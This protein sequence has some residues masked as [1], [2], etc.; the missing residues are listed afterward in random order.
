[1]GEV[2]PAAFPGSGIETT[3]LSQR[4]ERRLQM[5]L[6]YDLVE[7]VAGAGF[8]KTTILEYLA[9]KGDTAIARLR[10]SSEPVLD[11]LRAICDAAAEMAP[12]AKLTVNDA[13]SNA[14]FHDDSIGALA[15][16]WNTHLSGAG[17]RI[18]LDDLHLVE[19]HIGAW[20]LIEKLIEHSRGRVSW[21]LAS[22]S[23][24]QLPTT[25]WI[26][27]G[28]MGMPLTAD[29]L[30]FT[31]D[32]LAELAKQYTVELAAPERRRIIERT[33]GWPLVTAHIVRIWDKRHD[34]AT[35]IEQARSRGI[36]AMAVPLWA[37]LSETEQRMLLVASLLDSAWPA[38]L[39]DIGFQN[40]DAIL[41]TLPARGVPISR[42]KAGA[43]R[44]HDLLREHL[45]DHEREALNRE[46][47]IAIEHLVAVDDPVDALVIA[48]RL[49]AADKIPA[50]MAS[51]PALF[52]DPEDTALVDRA[53]SIVPSRVKNSD[54]AV[55]AVAASRAYRNGSLDR[56]VAL[57]ER[58]I[59][60]GK[61]NLRA[62]V[63]RRLA[64]LQVNRANWTD[65]CRLCDI[66][67]GSVEVGNFAEIAEIAGT[68]GVALANSGAHQDAQFAI[69]AALKN[70]AQ[71]DDAKLRARTFQRAGLVAFVADR[72]A[73]AQEAA[74]EAAWIA[75]SEGAQDIIMRVQMLLYAIAL[76]KGEPN[77]IAAF[78]AE[79]TV[80]A[81]ARAADR[82]HM[83]T[84]LIA[85]LAL[86]AQEGDRDR[87]AHLRERLRMLGTT[88]SVHA[89]FQAALA[90]AELEAFDARYG[91]AATTLENVSDS[92]MRPAERVERDGVLSLVLA[93]A[94]DD[95]AAADHAR[96][97]L[98]MAQTLREKANPTDRR[99]LEIAS[100]CAVAVSLRMGRRFEASRALATLR[101]SRLD[102]IRI[103]AR[104]VSRLS[105]GLAPEPE[106]DRE[107]AG[108]AT[109]IE[110]LFR[111]HA[112]R[113]VSLT[114]AERRV[115][116]LL[117]EGNSSKEIGAY[118]G[119]SSSTIDNH[120]FSIMQKLG[121]RNRL[122]AVTMA[123]E[124]ALLD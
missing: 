13:Y 23:P 1:M 6:E 106:A 14:H 70:V 50:I 34:D 74:T 32:D 113:E 12:G 54:P 69:E 18:A 79:Q 84:A 19:G 93:L 108:Y 83:R 30:A 105:R 67:D 120:I 82:P 38:L 35:A 46:G 2:V 66:A 48:T 51:Q 4:L 71:T 62:L 53:L 114:A 57:Y 55:V 122:E 91:A 21:V 43:Y 98:R 110:R 36:D 17:H 94:E 96:E 68:R 124:R 78:H 8:G 109:L 56:A 24:L 119:R 37:R 15:M 81:A 61:G 11:M 99:I 49:G 76:A 3:P 102:A 73:E 33:L 104:T 111:R 26:A 115:L 92:D 40:A 97:T 107:M 7:I 87:A 72:L 22:R 64:V 41:A 77:Y 112:S 45:F 60:G 101:R 75:E 5:A 47:R 59:A 88:T 39:R 89:A 63:A 100:I 25:L 117:G 90:Q 29:D 52:L 16:W 31:E 85:L 28:R 9:G 65:A 121:A 123:R 27:A 116:A 118:L 80:L 86:A 44:V 103:L 20:E 58:A 95:Q 10:P 42:D